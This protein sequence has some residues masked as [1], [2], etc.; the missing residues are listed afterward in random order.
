MNLNWVKCMG[1][2]WCPLLRV[3]LDHTHFN[4]LEGVYIIWHGGSEPGTVY[5][6]K[7]RIS[8]RLKA[9]KIDPHVLRYSADDLFVTWA[10]V[11]AK[12]QN[13]IERFLADALKPKVGIAHPIA[14]K[15]NVNLPW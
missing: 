2:R 8:H 1:D 3:D 5:V 14:P 7:G 15:I 12:F 9:H 6:G 11:E 10:R 4:N 13:G